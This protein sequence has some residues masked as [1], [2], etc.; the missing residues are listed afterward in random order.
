MLRK[1]PKF[2]K[3]K[4]EYI[5]VLENDLGTYGRSFILHRDSTDCPMHAKVCDLICELV[6]PLN[7]IQRVASNNLFLFPYFFSEYFPSA[8]TD[9]IVNYSTKN[10]RAY[11][12]ADDLKLLFLLW[13]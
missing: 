6:P 3:N 7:L 5:Q 1:I 8:Q 2:H 10:V 4:T 11:I 9:V 12:F 13:C